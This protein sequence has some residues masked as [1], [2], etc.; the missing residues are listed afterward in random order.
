MFLQWEKICW[1]STN[2]MIRVYCCLHTFATWRPTNCPHKH[3][4]SVN[5]PAVRSLQSYGREYSTWYFLQLNI[6]VA[7]LIGCADRRRDVSWWLMSPCARYN[8]P[9]SHRTNG[10]PAPLS[11]NCSQYSVY[12]K[13]KYWYWSVK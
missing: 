4:A 9:C 5:T 11:R 8:R 2:L 3:I 7:V 1:L 6:I 10:L 12:S 13:R